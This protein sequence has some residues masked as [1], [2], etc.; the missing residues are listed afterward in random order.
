MFDVI[1]EVALPLLIYIFF[2]HTGVGFV[3]SGQIEV[4]SYG[5][6]TEVWRVRMKGTKEPNTQRTVIL[7]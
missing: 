2:C 6:G 4:C 1:V 5:V 7:S 3:G